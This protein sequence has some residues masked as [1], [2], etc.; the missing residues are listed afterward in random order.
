MKIKSFKRKSDKRPVS[1]KVKEILDFEEK[2][3]IK[4]IKT[5]KE[6][7]KKSENLK[8]DLIKLVTKLKKEGRKIVGYAASSKG[9]IVLNYSN[10]VR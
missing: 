6:F 3:G 5:Y 8:N 2:I 7:A 4:D 1:K 10:I 9:N